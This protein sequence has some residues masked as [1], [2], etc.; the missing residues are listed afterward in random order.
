MSRGVLVLGV[1]AWGEGRN[2]ISHVWGGG[3]GGGNDISHVQGG[4]IILVLGGR[5]GGEMMQVMS[6]GVL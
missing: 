5:G 3:G 1:G 6:R 4:A 2:D